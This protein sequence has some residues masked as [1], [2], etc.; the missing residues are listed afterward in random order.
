MHH[1][2]RPNRKRVIG[3]CKRTAKALPKKNLHDFALQSYEGLTHGIEKSRRAGGHSGSSVTFSPNFL[4][5]SASPAFSHVGLKIGKSPPPLWTRH[6]EHPEF[7]PCP[8]PAL[9]LYLKLGFREVSMAETPY[10]RA[11][12]RMALDL[13]NVRTSR[14]GNNGYAVITVHPRS[15][16]SPVGTHAQS[17]QNYPAGLPDFCL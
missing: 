10:A 15:H 1:W 8:S 11:D 6:P 16:C 12:I 13:E 9:H 7:Y 5:E 2:I 17:R 3:L 14:L 4:F